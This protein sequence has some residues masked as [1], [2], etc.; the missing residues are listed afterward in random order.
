MKFN[1]L[2]LDYD[3]TIARD[4]VLDPG[5]RSAIAEARKQ[6][7]IVVIVTGRILADLERAA[8]NLHFV[9]AIVAE[10]GAVLWFAN[11]HSRQLS[12]STSTKFLHELSRRG[13][14]YS[15]GQSI[16]ELDAADAPQTLAI[17]R[18]LELPL[19]FLFN[20]SR[21]M[22]LPQ[23]VSKGAGLRE[24]LSTLRLSVH[25]AIGIGDAE[26]DHDLLATCEHG[27]AV[28]WGSKLLQE[29]ADE[30]LEGDGPAA[31][32]GYIRRAAQ[33]LRLPT[34]KI[35]QHRLSLGTAEDGHEL[36]LAIR[37]MNTLIAGDP[38]S[39]KSWVAGLMCEQLILQGYSLCIID[40]EGDYRSLETLP[41]VVVFGGED[42]PPELPDLARVLRHPDMSVVIDLSH[43]PYPEK[44]NYMKS[45]L[46]MLSSIRTKTGLPHRIVIDEAHYF[47]HEPN[48]SAL[49][50]L[51]LGSY[52]FITYRLADLQPA[53]RN[54]IEYILV[55]HTMEPRE[56]ETLTGMLN[57]RGN[58][59]S[60]I[61]DLS[62]LLIDEAIL[63]PGIDE[64]D[65]QCSKF[66]LFP[67]LTPHVRHKM[68]YLDLQLLVEQGFWFTDRGKLIDRPAKT[69]SSFLSLL[70]IVSPD[71]LA[72][73]AQHGDFSRWI[74]NVFHDHA[75]AS[76]IRKVEQ[77]FRL[78]HV[79]DL[80]TSISKLVRDRYE[81]SPAS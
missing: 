16:V 78:G 40:P 66:R 35:G 79:Y 71:V 34:E 14:N 1:V 32:A 33:N 74:A 73:H 77:R 48:I 10:N 62:S 44:I 43:A 20:R 11:G 52:T 63:L 76:D 30:V 6:G 31:V 8:G 55:K 38:G 49:V 4:G 47:L 13:L 61:P 59:K 68:K 53:V 70:E 45:L 2:A 19:V 41:G 65:G 72:A 81:L 58:C 23:S 64:L 39:G 46:P 26:N 29:A 5:V 80:T 54:V 50:D 37:G 36:T 69:L 24:A 15:A 22:V 56:I 42:P 18:E 21:M 75:L 25:N 60:M 27:V 12:Y 51:S 9:D 67:R 3:G 57:A 28:R 17:V 7:I